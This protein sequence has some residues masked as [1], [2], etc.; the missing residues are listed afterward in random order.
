MEINETAININPYE[1]IQIVYFVKKFRTMME[2]GRVIPDKESHGRKLISWQHFKTV[3]DKFNKTDLFGGTHRRKLIIKLT[4]DPYARAAGSYSWQTDSI[5]VN[6][7]HISKWK[8]EGVVSI[9]YSEMRNILSHEMIHHKQHILHS[10]HDV[11]PFASKKKYFDKATE[12]GAWGAEAVEKIRQDFEPFNLKGR[13]LTDY[14][15]KYLKTHGL[16]D[17][18]LRNL[19]AHNLPA[20]KRIMKRALL[21]TLRHNKYN[22]RGVEI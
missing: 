3:A 1:R 22:S 8:I 7:E 4:M 2:A 12:H 10:P 9:D 11:N 16:T 18:T 5:T 19:K 17:T 6:I 20:W 13:D 21:A 14:I 15:V